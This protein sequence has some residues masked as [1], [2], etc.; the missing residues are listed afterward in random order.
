M[1]QSPKISAVSSKRQTKII[2]RMIR[3]G[4]LPFTK[5]LVCVPLTVIVYDDANN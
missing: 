1:I 5:V 2:K 4:T 3:N